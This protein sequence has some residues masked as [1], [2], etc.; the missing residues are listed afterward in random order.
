VRRTELLK[1]LLVKHNLDPE[2]I[3]VET[4]PEEPKPEMK[5]N[6]SFRG[7]DMSNPQVLGI[8]KQGG[9]EVM[10]PIDPAT[11]QPIVQPQPQQAGAAQPVQQPH[12]GAVPQAEQINKHQ[13]RGGG[14]PT[15]N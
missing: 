14:A 1:A 9:I 4:P 3:V 15:V 6:F 12:P 2:K 8:L 7:E 10:P 5:F 13:M 11:G